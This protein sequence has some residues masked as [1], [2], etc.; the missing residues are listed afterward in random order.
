ML[1][2]DASGP[3]LRECLAYIRHDINRQYCLA[4]SGLSKDTDRVNRMETLRDP[5]VRSVSRRISANKRLITEYEIKPYRGRVTLFCAEHDPYGVA[6]KNSTGGWEHYAQGGVDSHA[7][8]GN[9]FVLLRDPF[10][11]MVAR[12]LEHAI[13]AFDPEKG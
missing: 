11:E 3:S 10:V 8:P 4:Q 13:D 7:V 1:C 9:H 5:F 2:M 6:G 12:H